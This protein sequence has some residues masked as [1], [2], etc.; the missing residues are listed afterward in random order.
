[1]NS[2]DT[3]DDIIGDDGTGAAHLG[4]ITAARN[5]T[6]FK[7]RINCVEVPVGGTTD[8]ALWAATEA[9]GVEDTLISA[10][11]ATE[12]IQSQNDSTPWELDDNLRIPT[13]P[14][15]GKYLYLVVDG[16]GVDDV[17]SAGQFLIEFWGVT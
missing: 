5:G 10:L 7:G 17:Y 1:M 6:I 3:D 4:Q 2:K 14:A 11:T 15:A 9:T 16:A 12:L 8:I 13:L